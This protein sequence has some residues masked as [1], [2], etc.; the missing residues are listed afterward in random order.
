VELEPQRNAAAAPT[1]PASSMV[2]T[3]NRLFKQLQKWISLKHYP[4]IFITY[5][6]LNE[7]FWLA[8][9]GLAAIFVTF[10]G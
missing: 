9:Q 10:R 3:L 7:K 8:I 6:N 5:T 2:F 1:D 4:L